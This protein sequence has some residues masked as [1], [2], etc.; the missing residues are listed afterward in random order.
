MSA[1]KDVQQDVPYF[2]HE[3]CEA[4]SERII[5]RLVIALVLSI[6]LLFVSNLAWLN[7]MDDFDFMSYEYTQDGE[8]V[9]VVGNSNGVEYYEPE[10]EGHG[11]PEK[12]T[13]EGQGTDG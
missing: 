9:N 3:A 11:A 7:Y 5:K 4:R 6:I 1:G 10:T 12:E 2:V 8:G 13:L